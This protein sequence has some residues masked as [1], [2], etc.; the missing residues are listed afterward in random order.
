MFGK[1]VKLVDIVDLAMPK[2]EARMRE[3]CILLV[4][5]VTELWFYL[6]VLSLENG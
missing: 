5:G 3:S 2:K 4:C 6:Q 1:S